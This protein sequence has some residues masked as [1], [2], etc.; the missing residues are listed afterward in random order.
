[1]AAGFVHWGATSQ[2]VIDTA[3]VLQLRAAVP[4]VI[5]H[6]DRAAAAAAAHARTHASTL[7]AGRTLLQQATP[8]TFGLKAAGWLEALERSQSRIGAALDDALVLQFGGASGTLA[9]LGSSGPDVAAALGARLGL[10][11]P[12]VSWHAHRDRLAALAAALGIAVG[13]L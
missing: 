4:L 5:G 10:P 13:T 1:D 2:D 3:L 8:I 12:D 6:I 7:M 9:A 11:A